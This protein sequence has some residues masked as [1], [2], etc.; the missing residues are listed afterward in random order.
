M[1]E[2]GEIGAILSVDLNVFLFGRITS[3]YVERLMI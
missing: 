3:I 2:R 1:E